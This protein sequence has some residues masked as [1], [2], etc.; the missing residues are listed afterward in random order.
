MPSPGLPG[1]MSLSGC[2]S[3]FPESGVFQVLSQLPLGLWT[4]RSHWTPVPVTSTPARTGRHSL[5]G[6]TAPP[7]TALWPQDSPWVRGFPT[8]N[9]SP[10]A[11]LPNRRKPKAWF[12]EAVSSHAAAASDWVPVVQPLMQGQHRPLH[13]VGLLTM[14]TKCLADKIS[15]RR[16]VACPYSCLHSGSSL[17]LT[18][19][20]PVTKS[21][22]AWRKHVSN[23][24]TLTR[25][26]LSWRT[27]LLPH[28]T[29]GKHL[30]G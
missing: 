15:W 16:Q 2:S 11:M 1:E 10:P 23:A 21:Q 13:H 29:S 7:P 28:Q 27:R 25:V 4:L 18:E 9:A 30:L 8:S 14:D 6:Q 17:R 12:P 22:L 20:H 26:N 24:L 3:L 19:I 5:T